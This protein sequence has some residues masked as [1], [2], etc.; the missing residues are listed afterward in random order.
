MAK[1][2]LVFEVSHVRRI[3]I[4]VSR[5]I[6]NSNQWT[7]VVNRQPSAANFWLSISSIAAISCSRQLSSSS[8]SLFFLQ[9][10]YNFIPLFSTSYP[11]TL[12]LLLSFVYS[13]LK[14]LFYARTRDNL[15]WLLLLKLYVLS[16]HCAKKHWLPA[17]FSLP[18]CPPHR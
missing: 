18:S 13:H 15:S 4:L 11:Y 6:I 17:K 1:N 2:P 5:L 14:V 16:C 8:S 10:P 7:G 12:V 3:R 9:C